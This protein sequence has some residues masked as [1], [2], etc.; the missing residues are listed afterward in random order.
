M[1]YEITGEV[2]NLRVHAARGNS[3][4]WV[5]FEI[6]GVKLRGEFNDIPVEEGELAR[7][8]FIRGGYA[9]SYVITRVQVARKPSPLRRKLGIATAVCTLGFGA[10][11]WIVGF[12]ILNVGGRGSLINFVCI[13]AAGFGVLK[14][15]A[16]NLRA[17]LNQRTS[18]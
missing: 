14:E 4:I 17:W 3:K 7:A 11:L 16:D 9:G 13:A 6:D 18:Q 5:F 8:Y 2:R 12:G 1:E 10:A 15:G